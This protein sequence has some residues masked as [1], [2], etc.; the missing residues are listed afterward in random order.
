MFVCLRWSIVA[1]KELAGTLALTDE[2]NWK[3]FASYIGFTNQEWPQP[4]YFYLAKAV[5]WIRMQ[6]GS[7]FTTLLKQCCVSRSKLDSYSAV[8]WIRIR[9]SNTDP[10]PHN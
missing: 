9:I 1:V 4:L 7:V 8:L 6:I 10:D 3:H 5:L 2:A